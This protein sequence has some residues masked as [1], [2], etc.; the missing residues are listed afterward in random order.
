ME[1]K[2]SRLRKMMKFVFLSSVLLMGYVLDLEWPRRVYASH[3]FII[4]VALPTNMLRMIEINVT[5]FSGSQA[6]RY[7]D[8]IYQVK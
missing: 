5:W 3:F 6:D 1:W 2:S 7:G 4:A 8:L